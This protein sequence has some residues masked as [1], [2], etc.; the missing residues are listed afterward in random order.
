MIMIFLL[1]CVWI[2]FF[3]F[4]WEVWLA[5]IILSTLFVR[6]TVDLCFEWGREASIGTGKVAG[7]VSY[8]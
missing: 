6:K 3:L 7:K 2:S 8:K 5:E 4:F 1:P